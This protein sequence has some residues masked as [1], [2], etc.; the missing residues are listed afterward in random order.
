MGLGVGWERGRAE[1]Q[2]CC[3]RLPGSCDMVVHITEGCATSSCFKTIFF[4]CSLSKVLGK[5]REPVHRALIQLQLQFLAGSFFT[6]TAAH[7]CTKPSSALGQNHSKFAR[8][9]PATVICGWSLSWWDSRAPDHLSNW[10]YGYKQ[11][12]AQQ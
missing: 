1:L 12:S 3:S 2:S 8:G 5:Y 11:C 9:G 4:Y 10:I 7:I 6:P